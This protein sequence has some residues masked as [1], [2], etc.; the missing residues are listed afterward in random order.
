M[1]MTKSGFVALV[2]RPNVGKSTLMN[3]IVGQKIAITS[4]K[5]QTTRNQI[6]AVYDDARGQIVFHDTPGIHKAKNKL[7]EYMDHVAEKAL[8]DVDLVLWLVEPSSFIGEGERHIAEVLSH[9]RKKK[10]LV[11]NKI[12]TL[13]D[14]EK[15]DEIIGSYRQLLELSDVIA[16]SAYRKQ[17]MEELKDLIYRFLPEG[18]R[19]YD[20]DTVTDM[21]MRDIAAE[22]IREQALYKLDNEVPHGIAVL[23]EEMKQRPNGLWDIK[24]SIICEREA[25]KGIIIGKGGAMLKRIGTGARLEIEKLVEN[26]VNLSLFVKV[27]RDWRENSSYLKEYGYREDKERY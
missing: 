18:P 11:I 9:S 25:H 7:S 2:G 12:D 23:I 26:R 4:R 8:G 20:E 21:P 19:Y 10:V 13:K 27:R 14:K 6:M 16:V 17:G 5:P 22:L 1:P 15:L 24:A 3:G